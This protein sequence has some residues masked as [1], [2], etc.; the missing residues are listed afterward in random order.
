M[1]IYY[2]GI[3][4]VLRTAANRGIWVYSK[5]YPRKEYPIKKDTSVV[6]T[7]HYIS[8]PHLID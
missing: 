4:Y 6:F 5:G 3:I 1:D 8:E 2:G 7:L